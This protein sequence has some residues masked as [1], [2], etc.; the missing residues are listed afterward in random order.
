MPHPRDLRN[1][2]VAALWLLGAVAMRAQAP[3]AV[4]GAWVRE[5]VP[6]R[7]MTA[8]YAIVENPGGSEFC[9]SARP[10]TR[11]PRWSCTRWFEPAR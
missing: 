4:T 6:G 10:Q 7:S 5:P 1:A 3:V 11:P 8:A 2:L 9:W